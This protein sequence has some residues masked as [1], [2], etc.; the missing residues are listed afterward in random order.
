MANGDGQGNVRTVIGVML[1]TSV[2]HARRR[3]LEVIQVMMTSGD[4]D[5]ELVDTYITCVN[6]GERRS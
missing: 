2:T 5:G 6:L 4:G 1:T 3:G